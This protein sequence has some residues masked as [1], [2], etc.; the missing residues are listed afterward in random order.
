MLIGTTQRIRHHLSYRHGTLLVL[1][2]KLG[3]VE[4]WDAYSDDL[5]QRTAISQ[6]LT[7]P[8][9]PHLTPSRI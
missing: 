5:G 1:A 3:G 9:F 4:G 7:L 6:V 8:F 2:P